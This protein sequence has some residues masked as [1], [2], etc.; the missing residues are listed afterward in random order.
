LERW[1]SVDSFRIPFFIIWNIIPTVLIL[2]QITV[3]NS[4]SVVSH[5]RNVVM[6][7]HYIIHLGIVQILN[8]TIYIIISIF[9]NFYT[10]VLKNDRNYSAMVNSRLF[11]VAIAFYLNYIVIERI[12]RFSV[13]ATNHLS[14]MHSTGVEQPISVERER[15]S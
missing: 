7:D 9:L 6:I 1:I 4:T 13:K 2:R 10:S 8:A 12:K 11:F 3:T 5:I 14:V 15:L